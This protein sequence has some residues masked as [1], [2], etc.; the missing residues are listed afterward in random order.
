MTVRDFYLD[1]VKQIA[2][3][4]FSGAIGSFQKALEADSQF[5]MAH[6]GWSQ[7]LDKQEG[8]VDEAIVQARRAIEIAPEEPL[9]HASL[10]RLLQQKGMISEAEEEMAESQ[11]LQ[12][13]T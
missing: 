13:G 2:A 12:S 6:L 5:Y 3:G 10:S 9:A 11:R 1:G 8:K 7:A 4:D